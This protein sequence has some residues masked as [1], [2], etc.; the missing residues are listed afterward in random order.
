MSCVRRR[1]PLQ[2]G[3]L[4]S[5]ESVCRGL[6]SFS[7]MTRNSASVEP[8]VSATL[9][10]ASN[11]NDWHA[12]QMSIATGRAWWPSKVASSIDVAQRG[13]STGSI[14]P[15][16]GQRC[17]S[18][19]RLSRLIGALESDVI[20]GRERKHDDRVSRR[21]LVGIDSSH[22][23]G[24]RSAGDRQHRPDRTFGGTLTFAPEPPP[25][26]S[27]LPGSENGVS[28]FTALQEQWGLKLEP[29]RGLVE[30]LVIDQA[31]APTQN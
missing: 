13:H 28:V 6:F 2:R 7:P 9:S 18:P 24:A 30:I 8:G 3:H 5:S 16:R 1:R 10:R 12:W 4:A 27:T 22:H 14:L 31:Q 23:P 15:D 19:A 17:A 26:F 20:Q 11:Q 29:A 21:A 25:G